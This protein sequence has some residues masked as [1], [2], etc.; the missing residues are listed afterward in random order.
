MDFVSSITLA[1]V[2]LI[3]SPTITQNQLMKLHYITVNWVSEREPD[4][5][6]IELDVIVTGHVY[7]YLRVDS[8]DILSSCT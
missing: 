3:L 1:M 7:M 8:F 4:H 6:V 2:T 5:L